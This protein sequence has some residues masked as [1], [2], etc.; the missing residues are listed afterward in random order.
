ML[1]R[2]YYYSALVASACWAGTG[3]LAMAST[4]LRPVDWAI[5]LVMGSLFV[6]A[7]LFLYMRA[8]SFYRFYLTLPADRQKSPSC[9][10]FLRFDLLMVWITGLAGGLSLVA[11]ISRAYREGYA[12]F[13]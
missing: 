13:G 2:W 12:V 6:F 10:R 5:N 3:L 4:M 1:I 11:S 7:G 9:L 8:S